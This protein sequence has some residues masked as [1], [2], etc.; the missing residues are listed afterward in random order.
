MSAGRGKERI[1]VVTGASRG[2]GKGIALALGETGATVY[3]TGRSTQQAK[4]VGL[5]K[6]LPGTV[7][8]T[9]EEIDKSGGVGIPVIC[10][11]GDDAQVKALFER[12]KSDHGRLDILVNNAAHVS[13][14]I[15]GHG[16]FWERSLDLIDTLNVGVRS[17]YIASYYAAKLLIE[18]GAGLVANTSG[19]GGGCYLHGPGYGCAKA[20]VDKMS[21][22][23]GIDFRP[24]DVCAVSLWM[25]LL[26]TERAQTY[27][28]SD[29]NMAKRKSEAESPKFIGR[30][31]DAL[32]RAPDRMA[33]SAKVWIAAELGL[34]LGVKEDNGSDPVSK[35]SKFGGPL[36]FNSAIYY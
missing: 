1:A 29:P 3:V 9:A 20:A 21:Y 35:R 8:E 22:D 26:S 10:D 36:Q 14:D 31:V 23:M 12:V 6:A 18:S 24:H 32:H 2:A 25:G 28:E 4:D 7:Y 27:F 19:Y 11:H 16:P 34:E 15:A 5:G 13:W 17:T 33:R 30:V